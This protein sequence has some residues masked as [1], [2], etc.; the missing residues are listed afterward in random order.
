VTQGTIHY[1]CACCEQL[2]LIFSAF[3]MSEPEGTKPEV[4]VTRIREVCRQLALNPLGVEKTYS[5][6][7]LLEDQR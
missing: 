4:V 2:L 7:S 3:W 6:L 1:L 5:T